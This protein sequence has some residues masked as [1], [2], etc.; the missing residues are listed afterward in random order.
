MSGT[1]AELA[2]LALSAGRIDEGERL[3]RESL[4]LPRR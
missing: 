2:N 3:A 1:L 4:P